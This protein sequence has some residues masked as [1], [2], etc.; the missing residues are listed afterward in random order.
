MPMALLSRVSASTRSLM[1]RA[2][3]SG[4]S[5]VAPM[6]ASS[7]PHTSTTT[8]NDRSVAMTSADAAS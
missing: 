8:G 2:S 3:A 7:H 5:V 4:S 1:A 6:N